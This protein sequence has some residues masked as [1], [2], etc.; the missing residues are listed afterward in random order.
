MISK[1]LLRKVL[2]NSRIHSDGGI[3]Q[4]YDLIHYGVIL[5]NAPDDYYDET[6]C[7]NI[8]EL[9]NTCKEWCI[10]KDIV[11][12]SNITLG[13]TAV[14]FYM[15]DEGEDEIFEAHTEPEV[16]FQACQW[17]LD[18]KDGSNE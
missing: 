5:G 4:E 18:N 10:T 6:E 9:M 1:E 3:A 12:C 2:N 13:N 15:N 14:A 17:I 16:V 11:L 8:W 7:V